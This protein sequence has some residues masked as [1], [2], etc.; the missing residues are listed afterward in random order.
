MKLLESAL[1]RSKE[2]HESRIMGKR[3]L[4]IGAGGHGKV[5][6]EIA[7]SMQIDEERVYTDVSF[8]DDMA[9]EAIGKIDDLETLGAQFD[10][11]FV[12]IGDNEIRKILFDKVESIGGYIPKLVHPT[13]YVSPTAIIEKGCIVEPKALINANTIVKRGCIISIGAI[14]DHNA[15]L[16]EFCHVNAGA[17]CCAGSIVDSGRKTMAG[18]I[19]KGY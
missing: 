5:V 15:L 7:M 12:A 3:L 18:E 6:K 2:L 14:I 9:E 1:D 17:I 11:I 13:A 10:E 8:L 19:V 16:E 4:I